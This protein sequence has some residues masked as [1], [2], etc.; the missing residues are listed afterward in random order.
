MV[1]FGFARSR[2]PTNPED[3]HDDT[4]VAQDPGH[5]PHPAVR[6]EPNVPP[7]RRE[8][9]ERTM[10]MIF[11]NVPAPTAVL[12]DAVPSDTFG[13]WNWLAQSGTLSGFADRLERSG[14]QGTPVGTRLSMRVV[15]SMPEE[16][17]LGWSYHLPDADRA[18]PDT[19]WF[20]E[21][22]RPMIVDEFHL[23]GHMLIAGTS[24]RGKSSVLRSMVFAPL[25]QGQSVM[26]VQDL[27]DFS[28]G[29]ACRLSPEDLRWTRFCCATSAWTC[30]TTWWPVPAAGRA[31]GE[32][33]RWRG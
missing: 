26:V 8:G 19:G 10:R 32:R 28:E 23:N 29:T 25:R 18:L 3:F 1:P 15:R 7:V 27:N 33:R 22:P 2:G 13:W 6:T 21:A 12:P 31:N 17:A 11:G 16:K 4:L 24:G 9:R 20:R 30:W 14:R 5:R